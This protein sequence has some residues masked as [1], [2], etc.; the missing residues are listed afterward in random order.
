M[1][2]VQEQL[3]TIAQQAADIAGQLLN[4]DLDNDTQAELQ[5]ELDYLKSKF[6]AIQ[7]L[8]VDLPALMAQ[9]I[10]NTRCHQ[11]VAYEALS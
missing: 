5:A 4:A 7:T 2:N 11:V 10:I 8:G 3:N 6:T 1:E 9:P